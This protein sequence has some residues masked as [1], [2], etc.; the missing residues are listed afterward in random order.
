V[1][2]AR[3]VTRASAP[4]ALPSGEVEPASA[5][6]ATPVAV[7]LKSKLGPRAMAC[8]AAG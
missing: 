3:A 2:R 6:P 4:G 7:L 8:V 1:L 5:T